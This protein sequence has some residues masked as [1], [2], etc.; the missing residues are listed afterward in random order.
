M[1]I[2]IADMPVIDAVATWNAGCQRSFAPP[3][4]FVHAGDHKADIV[5]DVWTEHLAE[6][7]TDV[8]HRPERPGLCDRLRDR[9]VV[10][11]SAFHEICKPGL[12]PWC[13]GC[14]VG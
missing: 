10:Q 13:V 3:D 6:F 1:Q 9:C 8:T 4:E 5:G 2:A 14:L 7:R 12:E 11:Q